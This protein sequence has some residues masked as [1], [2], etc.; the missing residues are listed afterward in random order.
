MRSRNESLQHTTHRV[1]S[2]V[3]RIQ[4]GHYHVPDFQ[5]PVVWGPERVLRLLDSLTEGHHIGSLLLWERAGAS[6]PRE[7]KIGRHTFPNNAAYSGYLIVDGHQRV[8]ALA[9]AF[10]S[11]EY[12]YDFKARCFTHQAPPGEERFPL[13]MLLKGPADRYRYVCEWEERVEHGFHK[14]IWLTESLG[15]AYVSAVLMPARWTLAL[16]AESYRRLATEG[17]PMDP[18]HVAEGLARVELA[19]EI[20]RL[21]EEAPWKNL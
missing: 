16:V 11:G 8:T 15:S 13:S 21:N 6:L 19:V 7:A 4:A 9:E 10:L 1:L 2:L 5:R 17:V 3:E 14:W 20:E 18:Q 12:S